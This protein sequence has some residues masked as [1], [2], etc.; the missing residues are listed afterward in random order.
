[1]PVFGSDY[2]KH[3]YGTQKQPCGKDYLSSF[4][5]KPIKKYDLSCIYTNHTISVI[6]T[7]I[8][9]KNN[10]IDS[11]VM[12]VTGTKSLLCIIEFLNM[13]KCRWV[14][15]FKTLSTPYNYFHQHHQPLLT[16]QPT[17]N[18]VSILVLV[19]MVVSILSSDTASGGDNLV[20]TKNVA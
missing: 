15:C 11:Q 2:E 10:F 18:D 19:K 16:T 4:M 9:L 13:K 3:S 5:S 8:L 14:W 7:S 20:W 17:R 12:S 6:G 1:M